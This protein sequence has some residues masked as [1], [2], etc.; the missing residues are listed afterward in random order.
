MQVDTLNNVGE[1]IEYN[2][3]EISEIFLD[4][5]GVSK[6][7]VRNVKAGGWD[8]SQQISFRNVS[9]KVQR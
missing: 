9:A 2:V 7:K 5:Q 4:I 3:G 6:L 1:C 8:L